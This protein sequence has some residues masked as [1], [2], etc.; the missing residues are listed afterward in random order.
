MNTRSVQNQEL[1]IALFVVWTIIVAGGLSVFDRQLFILD[2]ALLVMIVIFAVTRIANYVQYVV[3]VIASVIYLATYYSIYHFQLNSMQHP[4]IVIVAF[5]ATAGV[6]IVITNALGKKFSHLQTN[7]KIL[8]DLMQYDSETELLRWSYA[9]HKIDE[10]L[11]RS[12]RYK[13]KFSIALIEPV[14]TAM[15]QMDEE[16]RREINQGM[17]KLLLQTCRTNVDIPFSGRH[18]GVILPE[19]DCAGSISFAKRLLVSAAHREY[20]DLRIAVV[21]FPDDVVTSEEMIAACEMTLKSAIAS[22]ENVLCYGS[23]QGQEQPLN[24][25]SDEIVAES[26][27]SGLKKIQLL[28]ENL[29]ED[30]FLLVINDFYQMADLSMIQSSLMEIRDIRDIQMKEYVDGRLIYKLSSDVILSDKQFNNI[31]QLD[32]KKIQSAEKLIEIELA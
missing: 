5:L 21:S 1:Y 19:T 2:M 8:T 28:L 29:E 23:I 22:G 31:R 6:G 10:E 20:L 27:M 16:R 14:N 30:E 25:T 32:V 24:E 18:F 12:R 3:P 7:V 26:R 11:T 9:Q 17:A 13:K 4:A 15:Q